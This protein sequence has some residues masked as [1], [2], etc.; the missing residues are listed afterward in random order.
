MLSIET[1]NFGRRHQ[2][3]NRINFQNSISLVLPELNSTGS[4]VSSKTTSACDTSWFTWAAIF[5]AE[6]VSWKLFVTPSW[7]ASVFLGV[8]VAREEPGASVFYSY[9]PNRSGL[10]IWTYQKVLEWC[11]LLG[12]CPLMWAFGLHPTIMMFRKGTRKS[13]HRPRKKSLTAT[14]HTIF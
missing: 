12:Q 5:G 2:L 8:Y 13:R 11:G 6:D 9:L 10:N 3:G 14:N 7:N 1:S 4:T